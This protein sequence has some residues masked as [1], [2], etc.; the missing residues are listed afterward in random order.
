MLDFHIDLQNVLK[1]NQI[2]I[3][4]KKFISFNSDQIFLKIILPDNFLCL[5]NCKH[6][7]IN[8]GDIKLSF[9]VDDWSGRLSSKT[10]GFIDD[11][12]FLL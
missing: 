10:V 8:I 3:L 7:W 12:N 6:E 4:L 9:I 11:E 1:T 2:I 5:L